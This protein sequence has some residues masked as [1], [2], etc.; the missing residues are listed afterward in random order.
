VFVNRLDSVESIL[1]YEYSHFD[2]CQADSGEKSPSENLGQVV[3]GERI[4]P[5]P[6]KLS[7]LEPVTCKEVCTKVYHGR[8]SELD[9]KKLR[10]LKKAMHLNYQQHWIVD[11]LP[12]IWCYM[13]EDNRQFC[14]R[15][16]P[17][18]C[19]VNRFGIQKDICKL[20]VSFLM[21]LFLWIK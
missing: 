19:Y 3:F 4:R 12:V 16:F 20:F 10:T 7:F 11:N 17:V 1:P 8:G 2:F 15:G 5:S 14:S 9:N 6:Y 18:G 13:T 21:R